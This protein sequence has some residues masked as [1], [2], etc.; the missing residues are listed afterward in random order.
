MKP[1]RN[2]QNTGYCHCDKCR[3]KSG[4]RETQGTRQHKDKIK[5]KEV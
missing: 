1:C 4:V 2:G 5:E 3:I